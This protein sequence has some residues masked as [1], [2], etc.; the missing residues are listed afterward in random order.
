MLVFAQEPGFSTGQFE[1]K[2]SIDTKSEALNSKNKVST[3]IFQKRFTEE[4]NVMA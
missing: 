4:V 1:Q 2:S 3:N